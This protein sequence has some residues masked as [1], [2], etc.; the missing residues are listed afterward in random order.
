MLVSS[1]PYH[2]H[3]NELAYLRDDHG[4]GGVENVTDGR[5][6]DERVQLMQREYIHERSSGR[7]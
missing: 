6:E 1:I 2:P 3:A 7:A 5:E 4:H